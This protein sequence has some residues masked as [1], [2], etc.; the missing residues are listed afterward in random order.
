MKNT[1]SRRSAIRKVTGGTVALEL[2]RQLLNQGQPVPLLALFGCPFPTSYRWFAR[3]R[4]MVRAQVRRVSTRA[5][6]MLSSLPSSALRPAAPISLRVGENKKTNRT[7]PEQGADAIVQFRTRVQRA[8]LAA[9]RRYRPGPFAG[10]ISQFLPSREWL[11]SGFAPLAW[12][13]L[14]QSAEEHFGPAGC[15]G[16]QMLREPYAQVFAQLFSQ[17]CQH[18][19]E[20]PRNKF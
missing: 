12:R 20:R 4:Q 16:A 9:A 2:A 17:R 13:A 18:L 5:G 15:T 11:N 10:P 3:A 14:A 8:T 1:L 7:Q 6:R 19:A